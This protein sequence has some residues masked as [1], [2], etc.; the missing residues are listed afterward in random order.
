MD[1]SEDRKERNWE[2]EDIRVASRM[3]ILLFVVELVTE[4]SIR[5]KPECSEN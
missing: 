5:F 3:R 2:I 1:S 4:I